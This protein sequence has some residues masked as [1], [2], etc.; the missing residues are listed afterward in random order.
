MEKARHD[1]VCLFTCAVTRA[2]HLE[3]IIDL[4]VEEFSQA[5]RRF[6]SQK[7]LPMVMIS[8]NA[9]THIM[10]ADKLKDLFSYPSL[11][12]SLSKKGATW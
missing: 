12:E 3:I 10:A 8:D 2:V 4:T 7:S 5:F 11:S 1:Y 6:S 9:S